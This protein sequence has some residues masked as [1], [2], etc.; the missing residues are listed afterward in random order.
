MSRL[1]FTSL[2]RLYVRLSFPGLNYIFAPEDLDHKLLINSIC[3]ATTPEI[4]LYKCQESTKG[5]PVSN[6][7]NI[8]TET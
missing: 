4:N 2:K 1:L 8:K 3:E 7:S 6:F 5:M